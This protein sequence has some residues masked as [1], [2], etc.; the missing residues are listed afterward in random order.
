MAVEWEFRPRTGAYQGV[1]KNG[2]YNTNSAVE[3]PRLDYAENHVMKDSV[4]AG[5]SPGLGDCLFETYH[6]LTRSFSRIW[7]VGA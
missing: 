2:P 6:T 4:R 7:Q 1:T 3:E 5:T